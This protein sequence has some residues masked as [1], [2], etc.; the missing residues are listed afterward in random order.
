[1]SCWL[2][3]SPPTKYENVR[4]VSRAV[5]S[6]S[7]A[8][9]ILLLSM[10]TAH[11]GQRELRTVPGRMLRRVGNDKSRGQE[12]RDANERTQKEHIFRGTEALG[13]QKNQHMSG[14][15]SGRVHGPPRHKG[16][17]SGVNESIAITPK[18][19]NIVSTSVQ[20]DN[21]KDVNATTKRD[22]QSCPWR[23]WSPSSDLSSSSV[24]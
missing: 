5:D 19:R 15:K 18:P 9:L 11:L 22:S 7:A 16:S 21:E 13:G 4:T 3:T 14:G 10:L 24:A 2:G 17:K 6:E 12:G 8:I 23:D 20:N 1:M